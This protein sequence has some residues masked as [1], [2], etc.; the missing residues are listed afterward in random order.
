MTGI[1]MK[2]TEETLIVKKGKTVRTQ[3]GLLYITLLDSGGLHLKYGSIRINFIGQSEKNVELKLGT[4]YIFDTGIDLTY[5]IQLYDFTSFFSRPRLLIISYKQSELWDKLP[6]TQNSFSFNIGMDENN[7][8]ISEDDQT[9]LNEKINLLRITMVDNHASNTEQQNIINEKLDYIIEA[10][11]RQGRIDWVH[12]S[13]GVLAT[14]AVSLCLSLEQAKDYWQTIK[15]ILGS[16]F[17]LL[18]ETKK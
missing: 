2:Y 12:T 5:E 17:K 14:I 10:M 4:K 13:I 15:D 8:P 6:E 9:V 7:D 1:E 18:I 16:P 3:D 11:K